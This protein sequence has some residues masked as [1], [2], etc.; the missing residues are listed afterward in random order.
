MRKIKKA[1]FKVKDV[2]PNEHLEFL[3]KNTTP[4]QRWKWLG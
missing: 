2:A 3:I 1:D 4:C